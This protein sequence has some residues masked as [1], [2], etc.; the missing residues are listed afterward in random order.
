MYHIF[1]RQNHRR[2]RPQTINN[3]LFDYLYVL[4]A[5]HKLTTL[6]L[7]IYVYVVEHLW[8]SLII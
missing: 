7:T 2:R 6:N 8:K 5:H 1:S 4:Y 3:C